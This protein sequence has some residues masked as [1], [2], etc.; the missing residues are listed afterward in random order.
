MSDDGGVVWCA[1]TVPLTSTHCIRI[2][3]TRAMASRINSYTTP[4]RRYRSL[5][6]DDAPQPPRHCPARP[7]RLATLTGPQDVAAIALQGAGAE[8]LPLTGRTGNDATAGGVSGSKALAA[9]P[10]TVTSANTANPYRCASTCLRRHW[11]GS[12]SVIFANEAIPVARHAVCSAEIS[13]RLS[14]W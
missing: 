8:R 1:R 9:R 10:A 3:A 5:F 12:S 7:N 11:S 4:A 6:F 14:T 2:A 13:A